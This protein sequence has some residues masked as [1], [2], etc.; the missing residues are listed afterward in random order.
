[1]KDLVAEGRLEFINGG[2]SMN[3]EACPHYEDIIV[4]ML[5]GHSF[6]LEE[7]GVRPR[8]A[9]HIDP[10]GHSN[11]NPRL[12][13]DMGID[14]WFFSRLDYQDKQ[15]RLE[16]KEM[17]FVWR[18]FYSHLGSD[19]Q[20]FSHVLYHDYRT[21]PGLNWDESGNDDPFIDDLELET[22]NAD[23]ICESLYDWIVH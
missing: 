9:W 11:A 4:N 19:A 2:W 20:I 13:A 8:I 6:L 10:F 18:P 12:F 3:D 23:A 22:Y 16:N 7:F 21:P 17:E 1:V 14:T 5:H 15:E